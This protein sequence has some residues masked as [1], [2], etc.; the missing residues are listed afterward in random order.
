MDD[1]ARLMPHSNTN[2]KAVIEKRYITHHVPNDLQSSS[3]R[4]SESGRELS[5]SEMYNIIFLIAES[6]RKTDVGSYFF[7]RVIA[8]KEKRR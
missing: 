3:Q 7:S 6:K 8:R 4:T 2:A 5:E 1:C